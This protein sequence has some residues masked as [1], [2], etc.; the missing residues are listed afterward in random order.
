MELGYILSLV[1]IA[2]SLVI[3]VVMGFMAMKKMKP[4]LNKLNETQK[5]VDGHIDHFTKEAE[6]MQEK[7]DQL[8]ARV[9]QTKVVAESNVQR[10]DELADCA[11]SLSTSLMYLKE[12]GPDYSKEIAENTYHELKTDVPKLAK[13]FKMAVKKTVDKQKIRH[14]QSKAKR[15]L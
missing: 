9:D 6:V 8:M 11:S 15:T 7:V 14:Q 3:L 2:V 4:T 12:H 13:T 5:V 1:I 10:F